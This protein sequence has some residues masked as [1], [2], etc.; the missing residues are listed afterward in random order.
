[1]LCQAKFHDDRAKQNH[2][3]TPAVA[4]GDVFG[5]ALPDETRHRFDLFAMNAPPFV[6]P[7][8]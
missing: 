5:V 3:P 7:V 1:M 4:P 6:M 2:L 8:F